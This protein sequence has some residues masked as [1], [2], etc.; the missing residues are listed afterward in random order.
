MD[1]TQPRPAQALRAPSSPTFGP[2]SWAAL[3]CGP[4]GCCPGDGGD[5]GGGPSSRE[6]SIAAENGSSQGRRARVC[7]LGLCFCCPGWRA[8]V[9]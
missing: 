4:A 3:P 1:V 8:A 9:T 7:Q 5:G 6:A 2:T